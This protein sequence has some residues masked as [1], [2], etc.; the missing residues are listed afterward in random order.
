MMKH[1]LIIT[2]FEYTRDGVNLNARERAA[3]CFHRHHDVVCYRTELYLMPFETAKAAWAAATAALLDRLGLV[4]D[5][6]RGTYSNEYVDY[7]VNVVRHDK[8]SA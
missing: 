8:F 5:A 1:M 2:K 3:L 7:D 4:W 6:S